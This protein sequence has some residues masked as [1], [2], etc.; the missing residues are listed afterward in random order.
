MIVAEHHL[1]I[2]DDPLWRLSN[3][4]TPFARIFQGNAV[5]QSSDSEPS[6]LQIRRPLCI[7]HGFLEVSYRLQ[8]EA[9]KRRLLVSI[10][11]VSIPGFSIILQWS[12]VEEDSVW[13]DI[14]IDNLA[15]QAGNVVWIDAIR[16]YQWEED[17]TSLCT[18]E[19]PTQ[20][21]SLS[22]FLSR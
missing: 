18:Y 16:L 4:A 6:S 22:P 11:S 14:C 13:L 15:A 7:Q 12:R 10:H 8:G 9:Q 5:L 1:C 2:G 3:G 20:V 17:P 19:S 21:V